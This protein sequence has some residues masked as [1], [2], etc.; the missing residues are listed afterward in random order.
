MLRVFGIIED[1]Q[2]AFVALKPGDRP[3]GG[4]SGGERQ[5][6]LRRQSEGERRKSRFYM[7]FVFGSDPP[8]EL[9]PSTIGAGIMQCKL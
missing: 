5:G 3:C 9:V 8:Y 1:Q 2:P 7:G 6:N 4:I